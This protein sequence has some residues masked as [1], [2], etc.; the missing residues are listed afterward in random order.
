MFMDYQIDRTGN[1]TNIFHLIVDSFQPWFNLLPTH[2]KCQ[3]LASNCDF[4]F[5]KLYK[6][7]F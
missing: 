5:S 4:K 1:H 3:R 2:K 7:V 6:A